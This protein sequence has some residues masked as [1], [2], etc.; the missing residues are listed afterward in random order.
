MHCRNCKKKKFTKIIT[1]GKQP[2]SS[3]F[4][5]KKNFKLKKYSLDLYQCLNCKLIQFGKIPPLN[6]MYGLSYGYRTSLSD[7][8]IN[9]MKKKFSLLIKNKFI[10]KKN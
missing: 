2:I 4:L 5:E 6:E 9:H 10:K 1:I 8:M 3:V 7:L